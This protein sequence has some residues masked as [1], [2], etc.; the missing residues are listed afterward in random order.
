MI[1]YKIE[2][3]KIIIEY[4]T[5]LELATI[6]KVIEIFEI[7]NVVKKNEQKTNRNDN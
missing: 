6:M 5:G 3:R 4:N 7:I 1:T 2:N